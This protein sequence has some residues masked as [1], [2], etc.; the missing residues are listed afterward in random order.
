VKDIWSAM[1]AGEVVV[2][3][4]VASGSPTMVEIVGC[5]GADLVAID[6]EHGP[7]SP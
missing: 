5:S 3:S 7:L 4:W 2:G 6:C 1:E